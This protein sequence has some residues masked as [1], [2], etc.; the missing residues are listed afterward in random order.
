MLRRSLPQLLLTAALAFSL[1]IGAAS[2]GNQPRVEETLLRAVDAANQG[3]YLE[4]SQLA[5]ECRRYAPELADAWILHGFTTYMSASRATAREQAVYDLGKA[6]RSFPDRYDAWLFHGWA[7]LESGE[8]RDAIRPLEEALKR[9]PQDCPHKGRIQ[10]LLGKCYLQNNL[11]ADALRIL[12]PL[13]VKEPY[14][15]TPE[16]YNALGRLA[17][18]RQN[19]QSAKKFFQEGLRFAPRDEILLQN[20]AVT[21]DLYLS[22][23]KEAKKAYIQCLQVKQQGRQDPEGCQRITNRLRALTRRSN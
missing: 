20:L 2:C 4:A 13:R 3:R 16:L 14:R 17:I 1:A 6:T 8:S 23:T 21:C 12:Q 18:M 11:Q 15:S 7:L 19:P 10:M 5:L 22:E 9:A